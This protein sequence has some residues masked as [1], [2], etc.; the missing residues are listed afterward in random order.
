VIVIGLVDPKIF[1]IAESLS[2]EAGEQLDCTDC[3]NRFEERE[4]GYRPRERKFTVSSVNEMKLL[5]IVQ[6]LEK[7]NK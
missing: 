5:E 4:Q 2:L 7:F 1:A 3:N 6:E